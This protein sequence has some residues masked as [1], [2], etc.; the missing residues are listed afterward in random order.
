VR[1][2]G[3]PNVSEQASK[4]YTLSGFRTS[5]DDERID[6]LH[7]I[8]GAVSFRRVGGS[9]DAVAGVGFDCHREFDET[10]GSQCSYPPP[11]ADRVVRRKTLTV[12]YHLTQR[13][14]NIKKETSASI[15]VFSVASFVS[16]CSLLLQLHLTRENDPVV[17]FFLMAQRVWEFVQ[18]WAVKG[19]K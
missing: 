2:S 16:L 6:G 13:K 7:H 17:P 14:I 19:S 3:S 8:L 18:R 11:F 5:L 1:E 12:V 10:L 15:H 4:L 9:T